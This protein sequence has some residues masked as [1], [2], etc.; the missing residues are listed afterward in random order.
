MDFGG[1]VG[2]AMSN[3]GLQQALSKLNIPFFRAPVGDRNV[4]KE[5]LKRGW[6]LGGEA[7]GHLLCL[8]VANTGDGIISALQ[9]LSAL[10]KSGKPLAD[11]REEINK[12]PQSMVNIRVNSGT[13]VS[14]SDSVMSAIADVE[15]ALGDCGRVL[16]RASGT[17]PV[18][19]VMVE[20]ENADDVANY[21][22]SLG[23][24]VSAAA[25]G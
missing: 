20:G 5:L 8:D 7:S 18:L 25:V 17:E 3:L 14:K 11:L 4:M 22:Q 10:N 1:V 6:K 24:V 16:L 15:A 19:R 23:E 21:A 9:A 13:D 2:T 12:F